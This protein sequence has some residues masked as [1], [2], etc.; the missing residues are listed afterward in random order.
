[1][2][3]PGKALLIVKRI[4]VQAQHSINF[5]C[6]KFIAQVLQNLSIEFIT[7]AKILSL[8]HNL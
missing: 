7:T 4:I 8:G 6:K 1:V 5:D 3:N 2:E